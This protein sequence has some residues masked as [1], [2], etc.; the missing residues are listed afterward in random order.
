MHRRQPAVA[1]PT[2]QHTANITRTLCLCSSND[3]DNDRLAKSDRIANNAK[4]KN[5]ECESS[6]ASS[7]RRAIA[8]GAI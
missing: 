8:I 2:R 4:K 6:R 1:R 7:A 3:N 5:D